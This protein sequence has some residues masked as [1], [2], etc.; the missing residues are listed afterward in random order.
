MKKADWLNLTHSEQSHSSYYDIFS[1]MLNSYKRGTMRFLYLV[2]SVC[3]FLLISAHFQRAGLTVVALFCLGIPFIL[4]IKHPLSVRF[5]Q[6]SLLLTSVEWLRTL[7]SYIGYYNELG[8]SWGRLACILATV[9][10]LTLCSLFIFEK[11]SVR[12]RYGMFK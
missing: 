2:P 8:V 3:S 6:L 9:I 11:K 1:C 10:V 7:F 4:I 5:V 12:A